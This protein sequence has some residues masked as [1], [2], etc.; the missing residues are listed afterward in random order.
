MVLVSTAAAISAVYAPV[1]ELDILHGRAN[2][3]ACGSSLWPGY[4]CGLQCVNGQRACKHHCGKTLSCSDSQVIWIALEA[5]TS[6]GSATGTWQ[7][8]KVIS[9]GEGV[10][11]NHGLSVSR[12]LERCTE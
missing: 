1:Q 8:C 10:L 3:H 2:Q 6:R 5:V 4:K 7:G 11:S 12:S 9:V